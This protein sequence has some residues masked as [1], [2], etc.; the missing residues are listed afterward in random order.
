[1]GANST[2]TFTHDTRTA[3]RQRVEAQHRHRSQGLRSLLCIATGL[4][5]AFCGVLYAL[6]HMSAVCVRAHMCV[7]DVLKGGAGGRVCVCV[8]D[9]LDVTGPLLHPCE[10]N[11]GERSFT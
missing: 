8:C 5:G 3:N 4:F 7:S 10:E 9:M 11:S 2:S 1:M 6:A